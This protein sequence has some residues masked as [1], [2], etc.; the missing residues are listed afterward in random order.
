MPLLNSLV[1]AIM[2]FLF[3]ARFVFARCFVMH[4]VCMLCGSVIYYFLCARRM[5]RPIGQ[6]RNF[7]KRYGALARFNQQNIGVT[8]IIIHIA[9]P[10]N[11]SS[12][13]TTT[14]TKRNQVAA[15]QSFSRV[16]LPINFD[17][18]IRNHQYHQP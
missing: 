15:D 13:S 4:V 17:S 14:P 9:F 16:G 6:F 3:E 8:S 2:R 10:S 11:L 7:L 18:S 1:M 12:H 5:D